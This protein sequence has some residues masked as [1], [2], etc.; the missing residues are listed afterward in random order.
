VPTS[1]KIKM[2]HL[3]QEHQVGWN[4]DQFHT[5]TSTWVGNARGYTRYKVCNQSGDPQYCKK[6]EDIWPACFEGFKPALATPAAPTTSAPADRPP[7]VQIL[8]GARCDG[9]LL[10]VCV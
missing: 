5:K 6:I 10:I 7:A 1:I 8:L 3:M 9:L 2:F 4:L